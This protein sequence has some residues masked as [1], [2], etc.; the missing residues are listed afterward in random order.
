VKGSDLLAVGAAFV[1]TVRCAP[2]GTLED[3]GALA[4][5]RTL[6]LTTTGRR[7]GLPRTVTV[8]FVEDRG[9]LYVQSGRRGRTD[10]YRNLRANPRVAVRIGTL[11]AEGR[12]EP[13]D[14]PGETARVHDKFLAKYWTARVARWFGLGFGT[15]KVVRIDLT[16]APGESSPA[17]DDGADGAAAR[18]ERRS[19]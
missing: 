15:G 1:L 2:G 4:S 5:E 6:E 18:P 10:W 14:D 16:S 17:E 13:V 7:S 12:A 11:R 3:I 8:W 19:E 9:V